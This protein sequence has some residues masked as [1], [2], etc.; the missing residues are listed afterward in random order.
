M[1][2]FLTKLFEVFSQGDRKTLVKSLVFLICL[3][4]F[5]PL[6]TSYFYSDIK[7]SQQI[8]NLKMLSEIDVGKLSDSLLKSEYERIKNSIGSNPS[9]STPVSMLSTTPTSFLDL[10]S[11][12]NLGKFLSASGLWIFLLVVVLFAKYETVRMRLVAIAM[13][14]G[15]LLFFGWIGTLIPT[16]SFEVINYFGVPLAEI[17][18]M[19]LFVVLISRVNKTKTN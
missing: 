17:L 3:V 8:S 5:A 15:L 19:V 4:I 16:F 10:F 9:D 11:E 7:M 12:R 2:N 1:D 6:I 18:L 14:M 13:F